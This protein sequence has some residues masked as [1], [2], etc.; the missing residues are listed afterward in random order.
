MKNDLGPNQRATD[1]ESR[2][3]Q[4]SARAPRV[5]AVATAALLMVDA[6]ARLV[7]G[8]E[9]GEAAARI[10]A[11]AIT[12]DSHVDIIGTEYAT[13]QLDPGIDNP[14]LRCDLTKMER[15]GMDAVFLAAWI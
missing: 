14:R 11:S 8:Q 7:G 15:G 9:I 4:T 2:D 3:R 6:S 1:V 13:S 12:L 10:H 5:V